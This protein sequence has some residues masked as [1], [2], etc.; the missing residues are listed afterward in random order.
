MGPSTHR[1]PRII[2]NQAEGTSCH[3]SS[4]GCG[5]CF[6]QVCSLHVVTTPRQ[7]R[8]DHYNFNLRAT[9]ALLCVVNRADGTENLRKLWR[10]QKT[11]SYF[12]TMSSATNVTC[13]SPVFTS[14]LGV[15]WTW[16][17]PEIHPFFRIFRPEVQASTLKAHVEDVPPIIETPRWWL[18]QG[19]ISCKWREPHNIII[20]AYHSTCFSKVCSIVKSN[21][22]ANL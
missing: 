9:S 8:S 18:T 21:L 1:P 10:P 6:R 5:Q 2:S 22:H 3:A 16:P 20:I 17:L 4:D 13:S 15:F 14:V 11:P 7:G 19:S 12:W